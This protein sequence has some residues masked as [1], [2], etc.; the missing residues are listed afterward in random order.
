[1]RVSSSAKFF[2]ALAGFDNVPGPGS[3]RENT[4]DLVNVRYRNFDYLRLLLSLEV[5]AMH[6]KAGL[7]T[8]GGLWIPIPPVPAFIALSG[9]LIPQALGRSQ[10]IWHFGRN[11]VLRTLP[12]LV[13]LMVAMSLVFGFSAAGGALLQYISAGYLGQFRGV[14]LPLWSLIVED[15]LYVFAALLFLLS[16]Q[17]SPLAMALII[18]VLLISEVHTADAMTRYRLFQTSSAFFAGCLLNIYHAHL[19]RVS[20]VV[21]ALVVIVCEVGWANG[22]GVAT[23][24]LFMAATLSLAICLPQGQLRLPDLSYGIYIWHAPIMIALLD[25]VGMGRNVRWVIATVLV[26]ICFAALSWYCVEKP[27]LRFKTRGREASRRSLV[28]P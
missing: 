11:R 8:R 12:A 3:S 6:L 4:R 21:P 23:L 2:A 25:P 13:P 27:F 7:L 1:M 15:G 19:R 10:S 28:R 9:F 5:V 22:L 26:T 20:W 17:K 16:L 18:V 14:T 24:P